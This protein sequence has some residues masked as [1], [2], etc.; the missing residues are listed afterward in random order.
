VRVHAIVTSTD[1][2]W[3]FASFSL[4]GDDK[5]VHRRRGGILDRD[6]HRRDVVRFIVLEKILEEQAE[7]LKGTAIGLDREN[8]RVVGVRILGVRPGTVLAALGL[9]SGDRRVTLNGYE[10]SDPEKC[11]RPTRCSGTR[12]A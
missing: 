8:G 11:S 9:E 5:T 1:P 2:G 4:A 12:R 10:M 6:G 7:L 3:S